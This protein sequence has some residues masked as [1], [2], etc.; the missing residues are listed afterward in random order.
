MEAAISQAANLQ[1]SELEVLQCEAKYKVT[2]AACEA[3]CMQGHRGRS[4]SPRDR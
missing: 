1:C 4:G 2:E 3:K